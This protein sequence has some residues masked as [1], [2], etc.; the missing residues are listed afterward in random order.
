MG[1]ADDSVVKVVDASKWVNEFAKAIL[2]QTD[3]HCVNGEVAT[4]LIILKSSVLY[5]RL[6]GVTLIALPTSA[7]EFDFKTLQT[8]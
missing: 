6:A 7:D 2:V 3:S 4:I 1:R 5:D 8:L